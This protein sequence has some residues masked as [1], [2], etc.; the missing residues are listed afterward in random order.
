MA[1]VL[2]LE[3]DDS[4]L[5]LIIDILTFGNHLSFP[6]KNANVAEDILEKSKVDFVVSDLSL[7]G[8]SGFEFISYLRKNYPKIPFFVVTGSVDFEDRRKAE[9][10]GASGFF[11][12]PLGDPLEFLAAFNS[13]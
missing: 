4:H 8:K 13:K 3:D 2:V 10:L 11:N 1:N 7:Q 6:A 12:K 9:E 5:G